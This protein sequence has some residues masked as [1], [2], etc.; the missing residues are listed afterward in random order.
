M[1]KEPTLKD[2]IA[3]MTGMAHAIEALTTR[4]TAMEATPTAGV[5]AT[6]APKAKAGKP[7]QTAAQKAWAARREANIKAGRMETARFACVDN[8][9]KAGAV[10][11]F[12]SYNDAP[13]TAHTLKTGHIVT[14]L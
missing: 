9:D 2:A 13:A 1:A 5:D 6:P 10:C 7:K 8:K 4:V 3:A 11:K 12:A 14:T